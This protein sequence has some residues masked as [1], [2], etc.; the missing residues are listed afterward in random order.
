MPS[1]DQGE[2]N[3]NNGPAYS[4]K[5]KALIEDWRAKWHAAGPAAPTPTAAA[6][7]NN[8]GTTAV[9]TATA[10]ATAATT[11]TA[12][13]PLASFPFIVHQ[14]SAYTG[15][16]GIMDVRWSQYNAAYDAD[17]PPAVG[18]TV[19][20]DL[21]D[22]GSPCGNVHIR[23][24]TAVGAR[25]ALAARA[26]AY[27]AQGIAYSGPLARDF[28]ATATPGGGSKLAVTFTVDRGGAPAGEAAFALQL[29]AINQTTNA[30]DTGFEVTA[31]CD[32]AAASD[33]KAAPAS[34]VEG[35]DTVEVDL[36]ALGGEA[37][38]GAR[39]GWADVFHGS[40]LYNS[41]G[42]PASPFLA[43]CAGGGGG[44]ALVPGGAAPPPTPPP[45]P[46][47]P[48]PAPTLPPQPP[49]P[50]PSG[51]TWQNGTQY[52]DTAY[53][54]VS[55]PLWDYEQC[56]KLCVADAR[57]AVASLH[58]GSAT[59]PYFFCEL[60]ATAKKPAPGASVFPNL[61]LSCMRK[62]P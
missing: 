55:V 38:C 16:A 9:A 21:S 27:G 54:Q 14:L 36:A 34:L 3:A 12:D 42:L 6:D 57:C 19:G 33:W 43:R 52:D 1:A 8:D 56:C 59:A 5:M 53:K 47:P 31:V 49:L 32:N 62:K 60:K 37:L 17:A 40:F 41:A 44:C 28:K 35:G 39:Y 45:P 7:G 11:T 58:H 22:P 20:T 15:S 50:V 46:P 24:K 23:N 25:T 61:S 13:D 48:T 10:T 2:A 26:L 51:C 30:S 29:R 18:L 4:C